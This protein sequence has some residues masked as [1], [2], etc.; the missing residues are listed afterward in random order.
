MRELKLR[1]WNNNL[2]KYVGST[3]ITWLTEKKTVLSTDSD[4]II[5]QFTGLHDSTTW[6]SL[7]AD[8][9]QEFFLSKRSQTCKTLY[10]AKTLWKGRE[11][12]EG[13]I[14]CVSRVELNTMVRG[15]V[16]TKEID[17]YE[18]AVGCYDE[19]C[20]VKFDSGSFVLEGIGDK[21]NLSDTYQ[22]DLQV[23]GNI[24]EG[25]LR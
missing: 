4:C 1:I 19:N 20:P 21:V 24:H 14:V 6:D 9:Q 10:D 22:T 12:Y 25:R 23:I 15:N 16:T 7:S 3:P 11:I 17:I 18:E 13:D 8:E 5:E 2:N